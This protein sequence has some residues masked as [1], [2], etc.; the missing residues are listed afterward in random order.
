[1]KQ[2]EYIVCIKSIQRR[3]R[4]GGFNMALFT[5]DGC[6]ECQYILSMTFRGQHCD[7]ITCKGDDEII[8]RFGDSG[9]DYWCYKRDMLAMVPELEPVK[10]ELERSGRVDIPMIL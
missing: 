5:H 3:I 4:Q 10:K 9:P 8:I 7:I 1:M 2:I 6:P